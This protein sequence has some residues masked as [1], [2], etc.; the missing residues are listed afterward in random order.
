MSDEPEI[1]VG[2]LTGWRFWRVARVHGEPRLW[3]VIGCARW[4]PRLPMVA[5][6][7]NAPL[8]VDERLHSPAEYERCQCG[9]YA[10]RHEADAWSA[11]I[12]YTFAK[13]VRKEP[14]P[15]VLS[16][17]LR[18][19]RPVHDNAPMM[20][21]GQVSL[22][23]RVV[24]CDRGFRAEYAYPQSPVYVETRAEPELLA[25]LGDAYGVEFVYV[26]TQAEQHV[27][28]AFDRLEMEILA[29]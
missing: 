13:M 17:A 28:R 23:G 27:Q 25:A 1:C 2:P 5:R 15:L 22:W 6:H 10:F 24:V 20:A 26:D 4:E 12:D 19:G 29:G 11:M 8:V 9:I 14:D 7:Y 16:V 21:I 18:E 3:S